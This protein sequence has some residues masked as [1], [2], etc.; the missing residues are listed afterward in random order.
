MSNQGRPGNFS[1]NNNFSQGRR[2]NQNQNFGWKQDDSPSNRQPSY[3]QQQQHY[4]SV[5]D[6]TTKLEDTLEKFMQAS[7]TNQKNTEASIR[8]LESCGKRDWIQPGCKGGGVE[9]KRERE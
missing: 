1:N 4:P 6:R 5:H 7:L 8:N 3:Q 9:G 2:N